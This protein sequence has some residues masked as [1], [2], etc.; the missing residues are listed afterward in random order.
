M[1]INKAVEEVLSEAAVE[2]LNTLV[3]HVIVS[4]PQDKSGLC[5]LPVESDN[6]NTTVMLMR[7]IFEAEICI[8]SDTEWLSF[9]IFQ[10]IG[11]RDAQLAY[12][13]TPT[14]AQ[15]LG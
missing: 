14:F 15:A 6:W 10:S 11:V 3:A 7:E 13:F 4:A 5:Y 12:Q 2:L 8:S 1:Q 9:H